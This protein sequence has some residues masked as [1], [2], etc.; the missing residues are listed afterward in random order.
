MPTPQAEKELIAA[1]Y[2]PDKP[3][4]CTK[5]KQPVDVWVSPGGTKVAWNPSTHTT[6]P[7]ML[8]ELSC[9]EE[10]DLRKLMGEPE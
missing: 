1:G 5:C 2:K 8:H 9:G 3:S 10:S 6:A 4:T 7:L